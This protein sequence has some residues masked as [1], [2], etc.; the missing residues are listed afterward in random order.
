MKILTILLAL[1]YGL[2]IL[3]LFPLLIILANLYFQLPIVNH[4]VFQ[5]IGI[6]CIALGSIGWIINIRLFKTAGKGTPVPIEPP[7]KLVL[8]NHYRYS[9]NP[10]YISTLIVL[11]GYFFLFGHLTL[12]LYVILTAI[13]FHLFVTLYEEPTLKKLFGDEYTAY[14]KKVPR[15]IKVL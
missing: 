5:L 7:K 12:F 14:C 8:S 13:G 1:L 11:V 10:M 15:W 2:L 6:M 4:A 3:V 9:R